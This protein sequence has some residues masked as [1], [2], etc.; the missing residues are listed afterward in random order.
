[1]LLYPSFRAGTDTLTIEIPGMP[2]RTVAVNVG[3]ASPYRTALQLVDNIDAES[4]INGNVQVY[5]KWNNRVLKSVTLQ[6]QTIGDLQINNAPKATLTTSPEGVASFTISSNKVG[7]KNYVYSYIDKIPLLAQQADT[8]TIS[9]ITPLWKS[10]NLNAM[11]LVLGGN[12]RA[13][14]RSYFSEQKNLAEKVLTSSEKTLAV[15]TM[16]TNPD[17]ILPSLGRIS[18]SGQIYD[19]AS[20]QLGIKNGKL[21]VSIEDIAS[22]DLGAANSF[23]LVQGDT[24]KT[25]D[26]HMI[27]YTPEQTDSEIEKNEVNNKSIMINGESVWSLNNDANSAQIVY[28]SE[29]NGRTVWQIL[30][31]DTLVGKLRLRSDI[32]AG[33]IVAEDAASIQETRM[34]GSTN[35]EKGWMLSADDALPLSA[36]T[37][38]AGGIEDSRDPDTQTAW[39]N[40][41]HA[42]TAFA[43]GDKVGQAT[44]HGASPFMIT[45]G[46]PL[47]GRQTAGKAVSGTNY[48]SGQ[49]KTIFTETEKSIAQTLPFDL[50]RTGQKDLLVVYTD[51]SIRILK[52]N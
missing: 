31:H 43:Q 33:N 24:N 22:V 41:F 9:T 30:F 12:D 38:W 49:G 32:A 18:K 35:S 39:K 48:E 52:N 15:T 14:K 51:G 26:N 16:L 6:L 1:M 2:L 27:V 17:K 13:N 28:D 47:I 11:Y 8:K 10:D 4:T 42:L 37:D 21:T 34:Q 46:D 19:A 50:D 44:L 36:Q 7:G 40:T 3:A 29:E 23:N 25:P 20:A 45:L 5:D